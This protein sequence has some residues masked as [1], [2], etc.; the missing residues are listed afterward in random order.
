MAKHP[1]SKGL[2]AGKAF[3]KDTKATVVKYLQQNSTNNGHVLAKKVDTEL[4]RNGSTPDI[5]EPSSRSI[6]QIDESKSNLNVSDGAI[7]EKTILEKT[8]RSSVG[9]KSPRATKRYH[10]RAIRSK[11][12]ENMEQQKSSHKVVSKRSQD[13]HRAPRQVLVPFSPV[14]NGLQPLAPALT[15]PQ[16]MIG[17]PQP[18]FPVFQQFQQPVQPNIS[19]QPVYASSFGQT[20][21]SPLLAQSG[22]VYPLVE[23]IRANPH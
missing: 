15:A 9:S 4:A 22:K 17:P 19:P 3:G 21:L 1:S 5:S 23:R 10:L 12:V 16:P 18:V 14:D 20:F 11:S 7:S 6:S 2:E 8:V 13:H